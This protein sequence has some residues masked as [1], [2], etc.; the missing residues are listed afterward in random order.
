MEILV[1]PVTEE[2]ELRWQNV[3]R[4]ETSGKK[5][6]AYADAS[7]AL[8][9][10]SMLTYSELKK[11]ALEN[12][13]RLEKTGK[14]SRKDN[15]Q[16]ILNA[17]ATDIRTKHRRRMQRQKE[18]EGVKQTLSHLDEKAK[19]LEEKLHSYNDYIEQAMVTLQTKKGYVFI[20][21]NSFLDNMD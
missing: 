17:I 9:D 18:I 15:F 1:K 13:L 20:T 4:E 8:S 6:G 14:I 11:T 21:Y 19:F 3:I 2:D 5:R 12:I 7:H 16:E 10:L